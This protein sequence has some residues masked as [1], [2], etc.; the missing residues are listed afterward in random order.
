LDW[1]VP[2][3][4][5]E[6]R[7]IYG[8]KLLKETYTD[9]QD[10]MDLINKAFI[11]IMMEGDMNGR[12]FTFPIPTYNITRDFEWDTENALA[13]FEMT[14]KY[15]TPYFQNF[16]NSSLKPSDVRSMCCRLQLNVK[17]LK[18]KTGGLFGSGELTGSVGVVTIN[19]P[20]AAYL[21]KD[22]E[23]FIERIE[24]LA[25][26]A[27]ESLEIK[28]KQVTKN[29][30]QGLLPYSERY[31]G[32]LNNHFST[33][34][35][36][37]GNE[38]ALNLLGKNIASKEGKKLAVDALKALRKKLQE[39]QKET[40]NIYNLEAT[41]AESTS[42]RLARIDKK[43]FPDIIVS[44]E[45]APYY[46]NSTQLPVGYTDDI[47]EALLHQE[48]LQ[49]LYTGGTVLHGFLG[50]RI[51]TGE[52]CKRLVKKIAWNFKLPYYTVTPT[53]SI[54]PEHG[55]IKGAHERCP[56]LT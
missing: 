8:G 10:E 35:V 24:R 30:K 42:F 55:Y 46:T 41:P 5:R 22:K 25:D 3:D 48:E 49:T 53:F 2:E 39:F 36:V 23:E 54:C 26:Y 51:D 18:S 21:S 38:A 43:K 37:G 4:M 44:G 12:I 17:E 33:I 31:L 34:G 14:A 32:S 40:G 47:F 13:L 7:V 9:F 52:E 50:E 27:K 20:R 16:V 11:E 1:T 19:L 29:M 15:G 6:Q 56:C 28:R 45:K